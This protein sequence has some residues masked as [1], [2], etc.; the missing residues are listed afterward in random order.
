MGIIFDVII[1]LIIV[2]SIYFGYKR[3]IVNVGYKLI[4]LILSLL[5]SM[6]L[7][8]P[9]TYF[10]VNNTDLDEKIE[11]IIIKN[12][13]VNSEK[14]NNENNSIND[15]IQKYAKDVAQGTQNSIV[16]ASA[17]PISINIIRIGVMIALFILTRMILVILR[18]CTNF[19]TKIPIL[20]QCNELVGLAYGI[21]RGL[22]VVYGILAIMYFVI[23]MSGAVTINEAI[24]TSYITK[25]LF[26]NNFM[27]KLVGIN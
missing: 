22:V 14:E 15:Y 27:L 7:Y 24:Q 8:V 4:A 1:I 19:I 17:K 18:I 21:L 10:I 3:G 12:A 25:F 26:E 23:T 11:E 16:E 2:L 5:I 6:V 20:K 9:V 13:V